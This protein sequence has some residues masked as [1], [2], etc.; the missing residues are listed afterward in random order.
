MF[1]VY[2]NE[3]DN[4]STNL[5]VNEKFGKIKLEPDNFHDSMVDLSETI[6]NNSDSSEVVQNVDK[7]CE[8]V[9]GSYYYI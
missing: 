9:S 2:T 1:I 8:N 4:I 3:C 6:E 5:S 7:L